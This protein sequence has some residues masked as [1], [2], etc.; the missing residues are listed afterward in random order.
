[1]AEDE[2]RCPFIAG[3]EDVP[4]EEVLRARECILTN[5]LP[6]ILN[7]QTNQQWTFPV[8]FSKKDQQRQL[9]HGARLVCRIVSIIITSKNGKPYSGIVRYLHAGEVDS[10][11]DSEKIGPGRSRNDAISVDEDEDDD[12]DGQ[13]VT[14]ISHDLSML[15]KRNARSSFREP[16]PRK[17]RSHTIPTKAYQYTFGDVFCGFGGASQGARQ[18][19]LSIRWGMDADEWA[20]RAYAENHP[21]A[22]PFQCNVHDF[23]PSG[24]TGRKLRVD[25]LHL[26]P[27]CCFF[28]SAQ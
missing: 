9:F 21:G 2:K 12:G 23:P 18:A 17:R 13:D 15:G 1:M 6:Q 27:P 7:F 24:Y 25:V 16:G 28:S 5:K 3:L 4:I 22:L 14:E 19:G 20:I 10:T 26:S 11:K 8:S